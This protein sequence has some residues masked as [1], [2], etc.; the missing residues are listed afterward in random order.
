MFSELV[1]DFCRVSGLRNIGT[2]FWT[3]FIPVA[4]YYFYG[5]MVM[6]HGRLVIPGPTFWKDLIWTLPDG[7]SIRP[8]WGP[9][10]VSLT[11]VSCQALGEIILPGK[12]KEGVTWQLFVHVVFSFLETVFKVFLEGH[13]IFYDSLFFLGTCK[14]SPR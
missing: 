8:C 11:W 12:L 7:I 9:T 10:V 14:A 4:I 3:F 5:I 1:L 6:H 13:D 2:G